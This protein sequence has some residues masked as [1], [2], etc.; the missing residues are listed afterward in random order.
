MG[1]YKTN[2]IL[3]NWGS[4]NGEKHGENWDNMVLYGFI[5]FKTGTILG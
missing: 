4:K 3:K 2:R 5:W 1:Q